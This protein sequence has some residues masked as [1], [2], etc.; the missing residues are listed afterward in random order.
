M[1]D[2]LRPTD[3]KSERINVPGTVGAG[4]WSYRIPSS[5]GAI[6]ADK[7]LAARARALAKARSA[8]KKA[9]RKAG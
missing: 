5:I 6:L 9:G 7:K 4:N 2:E 1:S 3:P 8:S